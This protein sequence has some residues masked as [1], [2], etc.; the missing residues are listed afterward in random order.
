VNTASILAEVGKLPVEAQVGLVQR[1]WDNI[2]ESNLPLELTE[3]Q[4]A[5]LER[6]SAE[7]DA[8]P[9]LAIPWKTVKRSLE[10]RLRE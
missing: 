10:D 3:E 5:E 2:A 7:L 6:R 1:I 8:N 4:I 9:G